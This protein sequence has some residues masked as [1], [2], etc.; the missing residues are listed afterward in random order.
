MIERGIGL[1]SSVAVLVALTTI[2]VC[3]PATP[4]CSRNNPAVKSDPA[5]S[6]VSRRDAASAPAPVLF[7]VAE[8]TPVHGDSYVLPLTDSLDVA[9]ARAL[10]AHGSGSGVGPIVTAHIA[11]GADSV[12]R[13]YRAPGNPAWSWHV[14]SF[15]GFADTAIELCDGWPG[16]VEQDEP[17]R[18]AGRD[19]RAVPC[20]P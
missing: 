4:A 14:V 2:A 20:I 19:Q 15:D 9:N 18:Q 5:L 17:R 16:Y 13:D 12:N 11:T 6:S 1:P 8:T 3:A 7:L 10:I